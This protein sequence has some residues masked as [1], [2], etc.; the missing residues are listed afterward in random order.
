MSE[1]D[2]A[3]EEAPRRRRREWDLGI[4]ESFQARRARRAFE[5]ATASLTS[6]CCSG[7]PI[8]HAT[9]IGLSI[10]PACVRSPSP[11]FVPGFFLFVLPLTV[12]VARA[13]DTMSSR[14]RLPLASRAAADSGSGIPRFG[15]PSRAHGV[16]H[17]AIRPARLIVPFA[18]LGRIAVV[19]GPAF[20]SLTI[21]VGKAGEAPPAVA[22]VRRSH[23]SSAE[24]RPARIIPERGQIP[25]NVSEVSRGDQAR[26]VFQERERRSNLAKHSDGVLP[27]IARIVGAEPLAGE[28]MRLA[29]EAR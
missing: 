3:A 28:G 21:G 5:S 29:R 11:A 13:A 9:Q 12:G 15:S 17:M 16:G 18:P 20:A 25:E 4:A 10:P 26:N 7:K 23:I 6:R 8:N 24:H 22:L 27:S 1:G 14:F 2:G 19:C